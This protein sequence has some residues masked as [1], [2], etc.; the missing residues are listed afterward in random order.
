MK[1]ISELRGQSG[2]RAVKCA[3]SASAAWGSPLGI[4]GADMALLGK[5]CCGR[6]PTDKIEEDGHGFIEPKGDVRTPKL[7]IVGRT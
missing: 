4:P 5:P 2:G 6:R 3:R 7:A 1:R